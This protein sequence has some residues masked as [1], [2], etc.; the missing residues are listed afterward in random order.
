[1]AKKTL[2]RYETIVLN[3]LHGEFD[4]SKKEEA[5]AVIKQRLQ[6]EKLGAY[7]QKRIDLLRRFKDDLQH[8]IGLRGLPEPAKFEESRYYV[9]RHGVYGDYTDYDIPRMTADMVARYPGIPKEDIT[10]FV[11]FAVGTYYL[12]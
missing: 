1:M 11:R 2:K 4:F 12:L 9:S 6:R 8:E 10:W 5:E 3:A 7:D